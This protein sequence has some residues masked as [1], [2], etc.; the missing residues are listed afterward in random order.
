MTYDAFGHSIK[1]DPKMGQAYLMMG[2]CA[3]HADNKNSADAAFQRA[4]RFS[5]Q[6][7]MAKKLLEQLRP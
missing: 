7:K 2:Y 5:E 1:H 4:A 6:K 3:L